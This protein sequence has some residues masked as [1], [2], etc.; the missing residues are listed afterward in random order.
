MLSGVRYGEW[1]DIE[2]I[3]PIRL[4]E[5]E[6]LRLGFKYN[7]AVK[8]WIKNWGKNGS[9]FIKY[10]EYY[11]LFCLQLGAHNYK[12][13]EKGMHHF[14]NLYFDLTGEELVYDYD[15]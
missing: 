6:L 14:Q 3:K 4:S 1:Y 13:L 9:L 10:D 2:K 8:H 11:K 15:S 12:V 7:E 5:K